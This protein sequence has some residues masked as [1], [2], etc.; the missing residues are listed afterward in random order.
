MDRHRRVQTTD[1]FA[2]EV[3]CSAPPAVPAGAMLV[4]HPGPRGNSQC[5]V[6]PFVVVLVVVGLDIDAVAVETVLRE[7]NRL[8]V[9]SRSSS[10]ANA[11]RDAA[12]RN[13][14]ATQFA[15]MPK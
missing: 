15:G 4:L 13:Q 8:P 6:D 12:I 3:S 10:P 2:P 11:A 1:L 5:A 7:E 14:D 9:R